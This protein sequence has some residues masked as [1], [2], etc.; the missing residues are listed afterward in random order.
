MVLSRIRGKRRFGFT[1][2]GEICLTSYRGI[3]P[4]YPA[5][6]RWSQPVRPAR[7]V[8][9]AGRRRAL[10]HWARAPR[11][12]ATPGSRGSAVGARRGH[13]PAMRAPRKRSG[14]SRR[15]IPRS[16][17]GKWDTARPAP[18]TIRAAERWLTRLAALITSR[19]IPSNCLAHARHQLDSRKP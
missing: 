5:S 3:Y 18:Q 15:S 4:Y 9:S 8:W 14:A 6:L 10:R 19:R 13:H 11:K 12:R 1:G 2:S 7:V 17:G 16:R